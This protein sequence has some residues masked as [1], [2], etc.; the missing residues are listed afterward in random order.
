MMQF[1]CRADEEAGSSIS[2]SCSISNGPKVKGGELSPKDPD[3][4]P[5]RI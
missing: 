4:N 5:G 1:D 2:E 3:S